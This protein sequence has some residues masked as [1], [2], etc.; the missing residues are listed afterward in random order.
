MP[1]DFSFRKNCKDIGEWADWLKQQ[2]EEEEWSE[3]V[4]KGEFEWQAKFYKMRIPIRYQWGFR[5]ALR[6]RKFLDGTKS[7]ESSNKVRTILPLAI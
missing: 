6:K 3:L 5:I 4:G 1:L 2:M 7:I